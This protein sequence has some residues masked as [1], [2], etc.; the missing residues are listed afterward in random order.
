MKTYVLLYKGFVQFEVVLA[1]CFLRNKSEI[2]TF[3]TEERTFTSLEGFQTIPH[4]TIDEIDPDEVDILLIPGGEPE[5]LTG[6]EEL[7]ELVR[8]LDE[9]GKFI[10]AIC[11][12]PV[13]LARAGVLKGRK[14]T[15]TVPVEEMP[16][17]AGGNYQ[18]QNVVVDG[19]IITAKASGYVDFALEAGRIMDIYEDEADYQET[20]R[21]FKYFNQ[22]RED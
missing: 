20:V 21:Y 10:G 13:H 4:Q 19:N 7:Y 22:E 16:E 9:K 8:Q 18:D 2:I 14:Y 12:G 1:N 17:F 6:A 5:D 15:T 3:A 11:A